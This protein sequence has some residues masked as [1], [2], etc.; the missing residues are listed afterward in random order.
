MFIATVDHCIAQG[1]NAKLIAAAPE[2]LDMLERA[3]LQFR[4]Y[5]RAHREKGTEDSTRKSEVNAGL[6]YDIEQVIAKATGQ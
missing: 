6:A 3:A 5:E 4:Y 2:M 1:A